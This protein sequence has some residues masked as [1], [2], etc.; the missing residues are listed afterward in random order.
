[1]RAGGWRVGVMTG[2]TDVLKGLGALLLT[3]WIMTQWGVSAELLPWIEVT[4]GMA[5]VFGHNWS[6]FY[7]FRGGAGTGPNIG[8]AAAV[9]PPIFPVG[10]VVMVSMIF[11]VG[12]ASVGSL[13][14]AIVI[15]IVV[16]GTSMFM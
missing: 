10:V 4:T 16:V 6:I 13:A 15:P 2:F 11:V 8:W 12:W 9:W 14:M 1:M 5:S 3:R 7:S